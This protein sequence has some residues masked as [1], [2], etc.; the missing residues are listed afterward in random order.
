MKR[1][2]FSLAA[3]QQKLS[4]RIRWRNYSLRGLFLVF[5]ALCILAARWAWFASRQAE[6]VKIIS[7]HGG[8]VYFECQVSAD[9][10]RLGEINAPYPEW[11][12][13][14]F[15]VERLV[16]I[17][18]ALIHPDR[19]SRAEHQRL[20]ELIDLDNRNQ[21]LFGNLDWAPLSWVS[22]EGPPVPRDR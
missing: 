7:Q 12:C 4:I 2:Q 15:G 18:G 16:P 20:N 9:E 21:K 14:L 22:E 11:M 3:M 1:P 10:S 6:A 13:E 8:K 17:A 5:S 19:L